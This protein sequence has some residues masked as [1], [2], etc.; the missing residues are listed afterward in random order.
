MLELFITLS[1]YFFAFFI[2]YFLLQ[3]VIYV[4]IERGKLLK[5]PKFPII[6][7]R[8]TIVL[9]HLMGFSILYFWNEEILMIGVHWLLIYF[10]SLFVIPKVYKSTCPLMWN[11]LF[12][13]TSVSLIILSRLNFNLAMQQIV[14]LFL[15]MLVIMFLP[16]ILKILPKIESMNYLYL[17]L[18]LI[19]LLSAFLG[20]EE[21]GSRRRIEIPGTDFGFAPAE[22]TSFLYILYLATSFR[23]R[24]SFREIIIPSAF[25]VLFVA[26]LFFQRNLGAALI[27][28]VSYMILMYVSTGRALLFVAGF[29]LFTVGAF[30]SYHVFYHVQ[31]RVSVWLNPWA[32]VHGIGYQT[33]QSL[34][35]IGTWGPFGSGLTL[36]I[37]WRVPV[38]SRDLTYAAIAEEFGTFFA[39]MLLGIY[40]MIF[41]RGVHIALRANRRYYSL[42]TIGFTSVLAFQ[43]FLIIGGTVSIIPLTGVTLPFISY[44]GSSLLISTVMIGMIQWL[45]MQRRME[46][47]EN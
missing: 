6:K 17:G 42:L 29:G 47:E 26:I 31:V 11:G 38:V 30:I 34:F 21:F 4:L 18:G 14:W 16:L 20:V 28:F 1:R 7:Q 32:Y 46:E 9:I 36:G 5:D 15:S 45:F 41:Y 2:F 23:K 43:T 12:F 40:I 27:F 19:I 24:L 3:G 22:A 35:A 44:G 10:V 39:I 8:I 13:L 37:P 25:A 33:I